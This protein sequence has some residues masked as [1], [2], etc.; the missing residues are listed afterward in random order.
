VKHAY[1]L[2]RPNPNLIWLPEK[3]TKPDQEPAKR[4]EPPKEVARAR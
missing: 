1:K 2:P 3:G 4:P